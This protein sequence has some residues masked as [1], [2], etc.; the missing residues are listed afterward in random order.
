MCP[1]PLRRADTTLQR[2]HPSL[3]T[4]ERGA[5]LAQLRE[6]LL[7]GSSVTAVV[8][9]KRPLRLDSHRLASDTL[10][11]VQR[12][13][14]DVRMRLTQ[15]P[16]AALIDRGVPEYGDFVAEALRCLSEENVLQAEKMAKTVLELAWE[17]RV[18]RHRCA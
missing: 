1:Y 3:V 10:R 12:T 8:M 18:A 11:E 7:R 14:K 5:R 4:S 6:R 15:P 17:V 16:T 13:P 2:L 9:E